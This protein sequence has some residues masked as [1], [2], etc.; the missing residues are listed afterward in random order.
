MPLKV[1]ITRFSSIGDIVLTT[2]LIRCL[3][4]QREDVEIHFLT[5][6]F[7]KNLLVNNPYLS[8]IHDFEY[9]LKEIFKDLKAEKFDYVIDLHKNLRSWKVNAKLKRP[10]LTFN[11]LNLRKFFYVHFRIGSLPPVHIVDRYLKAVKSLG[12]KNDGK[13]LDHFI[14]EGEEVKVDEFPIE[15]RNG[16]LTWVIG[17]KHYTKTF[18]EHKIIEILQKVNRP[19]VLLGGPEDRERG[20]RIA[21]EFYYVINKCGDYSLNQCASLINQSEKVITNDTGLMHIAAA[22][23]KPVISLW[24]NTIPEFGM[25][26]YYGDN[27]SKEEE[28]SRIIEVDNLYC[29]PC[30]KIGFMK[31]P[32]GHFRCM[33]EINNESVLDAI[34]DTSADNYNS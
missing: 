31:C 33:R 23:E 16:F 32:E 1:L 17:A 2:P 21:G 20:S 13:G 19:V 9:N 22:L 15:F 18:P 4:N 6:S 11:K 5:K 30:S 3:K 24:G 27:T 7:Y 14:P 10:V 28:L 25:S 8:K 29:R 26:P 34:S 12:V